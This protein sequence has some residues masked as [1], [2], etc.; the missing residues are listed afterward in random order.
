[1]PRCLFPE[2]F[3]NFSREI[4]EDIRQQ[5]FDIEGGY[6]SNNLFVL[7]FLQTIFFIC[8]N[9]ATNYFYV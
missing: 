5:P 9:K 7:Y 4:S 8:D 6:L 1:M 3:I 2:I